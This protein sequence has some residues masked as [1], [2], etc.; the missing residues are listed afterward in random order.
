MG[1]KLSLL[2][3]FYFALLSCQLAQMSFADANFVHELLNKTKNEASP[4]FTFTFRYVDDVSFISL[5]KSI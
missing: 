3:P 4:S 1:Y 5:K 2:C